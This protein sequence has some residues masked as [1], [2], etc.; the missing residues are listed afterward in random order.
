[1]KLPRRDFLKLSTDL[2]FGLGGLLGLRGL[3]RYLSYQPDPPPQTE[4]NLAAASGYPVGSRTLLPE[5]PAVL[6]NEQ[7][8]F[9]AYSLACTHLG[10]IVEAQGESYFLCPCHG[11]RYDR[12]GRV[13][14]GPA[15]EPLRA[16]RVEEQEDGTLRL[17]TK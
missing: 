5:V 2:L 3:L 12:H 1:M 17:Y 9:I 4:F 10:C 6:Y 7:G 8:K 14:A 16:L 13:L 11:S 15:R